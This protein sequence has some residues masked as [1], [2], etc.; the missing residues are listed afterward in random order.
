MPDGFEVAPSSIRD[1][2]QLGE[3]YKGGDKILQKRLRSGL[4]AAAKPLSEQ[5]VREGSEAMP[6]AGG[7][8]AR[9]AAA[10]GAVTTSLAGRTV[11]V[12][13]RATNR[14]KDALGALDSGKLRHPVFGEKRLKLSA[15]G[16]LGSAWVAQDV[17][18]HKFSE[19]FDRGAPLARARLR[20]EMQK[21][22][23]E[24]AKEA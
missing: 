4:Q 15:G 20:L 6:A 3:A 19:A 9:I 14:Q 7:L 10:K 11:A 8:R 2:R 16:A 5:V 23:D 17:P 1:L 18:A 22:L 13:I 24:I 21:A 12:S